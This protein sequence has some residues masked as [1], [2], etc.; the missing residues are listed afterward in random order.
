MR[1]IVIRIFSLPLICGI[2][3]ISPRSL[4]VEAVDGYDGGVTRHGTSI[5]NSGLL[6]QA[7]STN[8]LSAVAGRG[9]MFIHIHFSFTLLAVV[10]TDDGMMKTC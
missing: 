3:N 9:G 4:S 1:L 2:G 10:L 7:S 6:L 8:Q 5:G